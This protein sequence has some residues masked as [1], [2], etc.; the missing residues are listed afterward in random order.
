MLRGLYSAASGM[1]SQQ[2]RHDAI[3]NNIANLNT[4]GF[5]GA[6]SISRSFPDM[7]MSILREQSDKPGARQLGLLPFGVMPE[8]NVEMFRQGDLQETKNPFDFALVSDLQVE[9]LLFDTGGKALTE[10]GQLVF[11]PQAFFTVLNAEGEQRYTRNG[12]FTINA[13]GQLITGEGFAVL[14]DNGEPILIVDPD[15][16]NRPITVQVSA[17]GQIIDSETEQ[18]LA[19]LLITRVEYPQLLVR[20]G[21]SLYRVGADADA[22]IRPIDPLDPTDSVAVKQ[23]YYERSNIDP[24]QSMV[25]LM[26]ALRAFEANQKVIQTYDRSMDKAVNEVGR[27]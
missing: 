3:T 5:K 24:T 12:K 13:E 17:N 8:E 23:G 18:P 6:Q 9:G 2:R 21:L 1:I 26:T 15:G 19:N 7:L 10:D 25:D 22:G 14:G 4:P 27:V 20:D 11:Q 16:Q